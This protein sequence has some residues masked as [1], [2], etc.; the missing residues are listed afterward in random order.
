MLLSER[1]CIYLAL[2]A[3][4]LKM[5]ISP[6]AT[7]DYQLSSF[8]LVNYACDAGILVSVLLYLPYTYKAFLFI[9]SAFWLL[10][11]FFVLSTLIYTNA[12]PG[13][14]ISQHLK[15][16][17]PLLF[18]SMLASYFHKNKGLAGGF[19]RFVAIATACLLVLGLVV[20]PVSMNRMEVW[21]PSYFG[22]LH[23]TAYMA[24]AV[25]F[26][27]YAFVLNGRLGVK[28]FI[29]ISSLILFC[30]FFG[31][32]VRTAASAI[33]LLILFVYLRKVKLG[34][35]PLLLLSFPLMILA[36]IFLLVFVVG[37]DEFDYLT[38]GRIS[39]YQDKFKQLAGNSVINWLIGNG[40]GSDLIE[41]DIWW[42]AAKGAH[43][44]LLTFLVEGGLSYLLVTLA[45]M[46]KIYQLLAK[47]EARFFLFVFV[48]TS[49]FSNG[50]FT[51]TLPA[52]VFLFSLALAFAYS[53]GQQEEAY[54][55]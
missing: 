17:L 31:W 3:L 37:T 26:I 25:L 23:T 30:I 44:D 40:A 14:A 27:S 47:S 2:G 33:V 39:M 21:W 50:Y 1:L 22:G 20:L 5:A 10:L 8:R 55:A 7:G 41:T 16:Y 53:Y 6:L 34:N 54:E 15:V 35:A 49:T 32:G 43:S 42:W 38:S 52:Y 24:M 51:R 11:F 18:F 45:V 46:V 13:A 29:V 48:F 9:H 36:V 19:S 4:L 12:G 28:P